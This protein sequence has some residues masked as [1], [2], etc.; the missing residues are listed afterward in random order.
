MKRLLN[1]LSLDELKKLY[2]KNHFLQ[3]QVEEYRDDTADFWVSEYL[4]GIPKR[5]DY[6]I[7]GYSYSY[8]NVRE[9]D[10]REFIEYCNKIDRDFELFYTHRDLLDRL[11][12]R[13]DVF[14]DILNGY[15]DISD[16]ADKYNIPEEDRYM[17]VSAS[18][19]EGLAEGEEP[20]ADLEA[21][22]LPDEVCEK[23]G[24]QSLTGEGVYVVLIVNDKSK[25]RD[26]A[27]MDYIFE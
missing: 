13:S 21:I 20:V 7:S 19:K 11:T 1:E 22:K 9:D 12:A 18:A 15:K 26:D 16:Y 17:F 10:Y 23:I 3:T 4:D 2:E 27:F 25:E 24:V 5:V 6:S 8:I 14:E